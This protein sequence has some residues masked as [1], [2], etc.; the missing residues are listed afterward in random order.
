MLVSWVVCRYAVANARLE[1]HSDVAGVFLICFARMLIS[2][3]HC[4]QHEAIMNRSFRLCLERYY[5]M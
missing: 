1:I 2:G 3:R 5:N 4:W